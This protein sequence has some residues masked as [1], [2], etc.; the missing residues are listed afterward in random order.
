MM[1]PP[2]YP[3]ITST[4][5]SSRVRHRICAPVSVSV[6]GSHSPEVDGVE[7]AV[8][9]LVGV[10]RLVE[11]VQHRA[12][13]RLDD[14]GRRAVPRQRLAGHADL[15]QHLAQAVPP[16]G[17]RLDR[18]VQHLDG[19]LDDRADRGDGRGDR[20]VAAPRR[21]AL[22]QPRAREPDVGG[23]GRRPAR[24]LQ[25]REPVHLGRVVEP[26]VQQ[27]QQIFVEHLPLAIRQRGELVVQLGEGRLVER[28]TPTS[29][30]RMI[31]YVRPFCSRPCWWMPASCANALRPTTALFG[32][33]KT[34]MTWDRSWL[35][36]KISFAFTPHLNATACE[37]TRP[38]ITISSSAAL[39]A[40]SP[41]PLIVHSTWP[42]PASM[43]ASELATAR[44]RSS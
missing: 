22:A 33:G 7:R 19:A 26:A 2:G 27:R 17:D 41:M 12:R 18:E 21:A 30:G 29:S 5:A 44:P 31:S 13:A 43:A 28:G 9:Q 1:A 3:K 32:W 14:V 37:R 35:V 6:I 25:M 36:R 24:Y 8:L 34:P 16:G 40:R 15:H 23:G 42:A 11:G 20:S 4:P 38:A 39:P 10:A